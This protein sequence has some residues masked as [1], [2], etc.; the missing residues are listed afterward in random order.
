[1]QGK[2]KS[3]RIRGK[4]QTMENVENHFRRKGFVNQHD[5]LERTPAS[6]TPS[7][8]SFTTDSAREPSH[9]DDMHPLTLDLDPNGAD[10][11][12]DQDAVLQPPEDALDI[13]EAVT[14]APA[15]APVLPKTPPCQS[16]TPAGCNR[17]ME[18]LLLNTKD[19][20]SAFFD[21][22][23]F[24]AGT[25]VNI[26]VSA[27]FRSLFSMI[28]T[29]FDQCLDVHAL[30]LYDD[31]T[32]FLSNMLHQRDPIH[33]VLIYQR[34]CSRI[35]ESREPTM[36]SVLEFMSEMAQIKLSSSNPITGIINSIIGNRQADPE[37]VELGVRC[38]LDYVRNAL[39]PI[40]P[41]T[42]EL[43]DRHCGALMNLGRYSEAAERLQELASLYGK[44]IGST[45]SHL[46][47]TLICLGCC[48][49]GLQDFVR[50]RTFF[51]RS[52]RLHDDYRSPGSLASKDSEPAD[53]AQALE[54]YMKDMTWL[55]YGVPK[56][57]T[58]RGS[59]KYT[60]EKY[61]IIRLGSLAQKKKKYR[62]CGE[63]RFVRQYCDEVNSW[64][65]SCATMH[66]DFRFS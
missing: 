36:I 50:A 10:R 58:T 39:G 25:F 65:W 35:F 61:R 16:I 8:L 47:W 27:E 33:L 42:I 19:M 53:Q 2:T 20:C 59:S 21:K 13:D 49:E 15:I 54:A 43:A 31:L 32:D 62:E 37:F 56:K 52:F 12:A 55:L 9:V 23:A 1:M 24:N 40:H 28:R 34:L 64:G 26:E 46:C 11:S 14:I 3:F 41:Y 57:R 30:Y 5:L 17:S 4:R 66:K 63:R 51:E 44:Q 7:V 45:S 38:A 29:S 6:P 22:Q 48:Y 18:S 60:Y